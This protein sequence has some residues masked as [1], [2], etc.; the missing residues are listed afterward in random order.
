MTNLAFKINITTTLCV[1]TNIYIFVCKY[2][3]M[4]IYVCVYT[5]IHMYIG[6]WLHRSPREGVPRSGPGARPAGRKAGARRSQEGHELS[7]ARLCVKIKK[8][9]M[10]P[11]QSRQEAGGKHSS[12]EGRWSPASQTESSQSSAFYCH[13][14]NP[15]AVWPSGTRSPD[16]VLERAARPRGEEQMVRGR[17]RPREAA[18]RAA[19]RRGWKESRLGWIYQ[20]FWN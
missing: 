12:A 19:Q 5:H 8:K 16:G 15:R 3:C 17:N 6:V 1:C 10:R 9:P 20:I 4:C 14:G 13:P 18:G 2:M 7:C 11:E